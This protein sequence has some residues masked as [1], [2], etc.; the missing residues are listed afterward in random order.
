M[1]GLA[2][3]AGV[4]PL[5]AG[6]TL[7]LLAGGRSARMGRDKASLPVPGGTLLERVVRVIGP[8]FSDVVVCGA[9]APAGARAAADRRADTGPLAGMEAGLFETRTAEAFVLAC[10]M[11]RVSARLA[12]LLLERSRGHDVA[13]PRVADRDQPLC[14]AYA[15]SVLPK[16]SSY[17]DG[18]GRRVATFVAS[19]DAVRVTED[20]LTSAGIAPGELSDIDTPAEYEAF[21]AS[22][23]S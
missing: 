11:P 17:L 7:V 18:G 20:E 2:S 5:T 6:A 23:G 8:A 10:D 13:L 22:L 1:A 14:A 12:T 3:R 4:V 16:L 19:L 21:L 9:A 15:R